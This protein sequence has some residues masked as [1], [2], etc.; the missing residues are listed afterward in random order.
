M[1]QVKLTIR[2]PEM[3][4]LQTFLLQRKIE[5]PYLFG[6]QTSSLF[7]FLVLFLLLSVISPSSSIDW[8]LMEI[9][10]QCTA[11]S[12]FKGSISL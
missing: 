6:V 4:P 7:V 1:F 9:N 8:S 12:F 10:T 5:S 3:P 11:W 2:S